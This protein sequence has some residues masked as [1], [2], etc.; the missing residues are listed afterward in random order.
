MTSG[1]KI[2]TIDLIDRYCE[3]L[4]LNGRNYSTIHGYRLNLEE[5]FKWLHAKRLW[6]WPAQDRELPRTSLVAYREF[7]IETYASATVNRKI[8]ALNGFMRWAGGKGHLQAVSSLRT[9]KVE[10]AM[11]ES[12]DA[13]DSANLFAHVMQEGDEPEKLIFALL[14]IEGLGI[15]EVCALQWEDVQVGG[16]KALLHVGDPRTHRVRT[17]ELDEITTQ[18]FLQHQRSAHQ[19]QSNLV[20]TRTNGTRMTARVVEMLLGRISRK[21]GLRVTARTLHW[22]FAESSSSL[23]EGAAPGDLTALNSFLIG[24]ESEKVSR[25]SVPV[26]ALDDT[27]QDMVLP[28]V[29][30]I[31]T[32]NDVPYLTVRSNVRRDPLVRTRV[33]ERANGICER[34]GYRADSPL[35]LEV[36]HILAA[37]EKQ[38]REHNCAALCPNCHREAHALPK[39][40]E[41]DKALLRILRDRKLPGRTSK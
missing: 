13:E 36:H 39:C 35:F 7:L 6:P 4:A 28:D 26:G 20:F 29:L 10:P 11:R 17:V 18:L 14:L 31:G 25:P 40:Q 12:L 33:L 24:S 32:V 19:S 37:G 34:C 21:V 3:Y 2:A 27:Y 5:T 1:P 30:H 23:S 9:V 22:T 41:I 8:T 16:S 38:D 15:T